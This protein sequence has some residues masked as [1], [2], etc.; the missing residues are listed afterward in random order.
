MLTS[1]WDAKD[2]RDGGGSNTAVFYSR[3]EEGQLYYV[4]N[5]WGAT[6]GRWGGF[7]KRDKWNP[8]VTACRPVSSCA[9]ITTAN[10]PGDI[11]VSKEKT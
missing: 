7:F 1:N 3:N 10:W 2:E 9:P 4:F 8:R 11:R 6:M 5:D